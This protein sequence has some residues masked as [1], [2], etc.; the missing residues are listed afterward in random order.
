MNKV[1]RLTVILIAAFGCVTVAAQVDRGNDPNVPCVVVT[2]A[3]HAPMRFELKQR[4]VRV[5]EA[6]TFA[7]GWTDH[8]A[9]T[10]KLIRTDRPCYAEA[11]AHKT[12]PDR[13]LEVIE[14]TIKDLAR[15]NIKINP[16]LNPGDVV[17]V[18]ESD[19]IYVW[20]RVAKPQSI[21]F[22]QPPTLLN[23][24]EKAGGAVGVLS[25]TKLVVYR[26]GDDGRY[27]EVL[28]IDLAE[29]TK[30]PKRSP[31]LQPN[32]IIDVGP[33]HFQVPMTPPKFDSPPNYRPTKPSPDNGT[34]EIAKL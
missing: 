16:L 28:R 7:G 20:G 19:P 13:P 24:I 34:N 21:Y 2:G 33:A 23:A 5:L 8:A 25:E 3:V 12:W 17:L 30:H 10:V 18:P 15:G 29:L 32:D 4:P 1:I 26:A 14:W 6:V 31:A 9:G 22:K 27:R 11:W